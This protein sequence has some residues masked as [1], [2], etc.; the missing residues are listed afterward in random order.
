VSYRHKAPGSSAPNR[1]ATIGLPPEEDTLVDGQS[2]QEAP[3]SAEFT[4][5]DAKTADVSNLAT[6][7]VKLLSPTRVI[8]PRA[9]PAR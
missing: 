8:G 3:S 2:G 4:V 7:F 1:G 5:V 9:R 6:R